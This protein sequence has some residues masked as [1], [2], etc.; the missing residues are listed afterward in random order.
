MHIVPKLRIRYGA[1]VRVADDGTLVSAWY[2][3]LRDMAITDPFTSECGR[4]QVDPTAEYGIT[5]EQ[6]IQLC[7]L[8]K[9]EY[10]Q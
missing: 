8:N 9:L 4:F 1:E 6:A 10:P 3:D 7:I 2:A 5:R